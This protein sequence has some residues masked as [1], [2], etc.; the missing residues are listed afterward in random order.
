MGLCRDCPRPDRLFLSPKVRNRNSFIV[1][2]SKRLIYSVLIRRMLGP[3][4]SH[5]DMLHIPDS[6]YRDPPSSF[7]PPAPGDC[8][9]YLYSSYVAAY[10]EYPLPVHSATPLRIRG[11]GVI[12]TTRG[13]DIGEGGQRI[14]EDAELVLSDKDVLP[15][16]DA[17][18]RPPK[19]ALAARADQA[20]IV[21]RPSAA[22]VEPELRDSSRPTPE[23]AV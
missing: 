7:A 16:Y 19:Y 20:P 13:L 1:T 21:G 18:D 5:H 15:A 11:V 12:P 2:C 14:N 4:K 8:P 6:V 10:P 23:V 17:R 9:A 3:R 22:A